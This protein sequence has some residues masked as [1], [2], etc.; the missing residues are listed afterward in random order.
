MNE[1]GDPEALSFL[2]LWSNHLGSVPA[3]FL[4]PFLPFYSFPSLIYLLE[5]CHMPAQT[6][7]PLVKFNGKLKLRISTIW[8]HLPFP[9]L[10]PSSLLPILNT[11][12]VINSLS[13]FKHVGTATFCPLFS[14]PGIL[15]PPAPYKVHLKSHLLRVTFPDSSVRGSLTCLQSSTP[16]VYPFYGP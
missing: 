10:P 15:L 3:F 12:S 6:S 2:L 1:I 4:D 11:P 7:P 13:I 8:P 14:L 9:A 5:C 16:C